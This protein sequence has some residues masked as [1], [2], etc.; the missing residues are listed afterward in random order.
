MIPSKTLALL[1]VWKNNPF[2]QLTILD[3]MRL[4]GKS[5]KAWVF[6]ALKG[7]EKRGLLVLARKGNLNLYSLDLENPVVPILLHFLEWDQ[8]FSLKH[9]EMVKTI[10]N[11][12]PLRF[13]FALLVFGSHA[14]GSAKRDSDLDLC[15]I[16]ENDKLSKKLKPYINEA[17]LE[18]P[19]DFDVH[20]ITFD[21][22]VL[23]LVRDEE[24]L[25]KQI[26]RK[27]RMLFD[28][29]VYFNLLKEAHKRGF[30]P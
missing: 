18:S 10:L 9:N 14:N 8:G 25:A 6:N 11:R 12:I 5:S 16:V 22:F 30:R 27:N 4:A 15:F 26:F 20:Y 2:T 21:D 1:L 28:P 24:N 13:R 7:L 3:V 17:A 19:V 23:M 29:V